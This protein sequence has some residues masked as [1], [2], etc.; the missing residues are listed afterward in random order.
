MHTCGCSGKYEEGAG[1]QLWPHFLDSSV[2]KQF[3]SYLGR[4]PTHR[5]VDGGI[6]A[7]EPNQTA[8][9]MYSQITE[10]LNT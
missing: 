8:M 5:R 6:L 7:V 3:L 10:F 2:K 4:A 1:A 9:K